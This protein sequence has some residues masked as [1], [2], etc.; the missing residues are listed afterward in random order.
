MRNTDMT[1]EIANT[2]INTLKR[3]RLTLKDALEM[4]TKAEEMSALIRVPMVVTVVDD[5]GNIIAQHRMDDSLLASISISYSKAY[6]AVALQVP[7]EEAAKNILPGNSLYGLQDTHP[8]KFCI[9]GGGIP[10]IRDNHC[11]GAIGVSGGSVEQ[12]IKVAK[13]AVN[14]S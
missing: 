14:F 9:F 8:G 6:T 5:G 13:Y 1:N 10:I 3:Q 4:I 11:I 7:T 2:I 12:D